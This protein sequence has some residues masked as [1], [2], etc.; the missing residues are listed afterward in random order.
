MAELEL[1]PTSDA[2]I[3]TVTKILEERCDGGRNVF[4]TSVSMCQ[5]TSN[6]DPDQDSGSSSILTSSQ[7]GLDSIESM[8]SA[9][10]VSS[11]A[12]N[13]RDMMRRAAAA[14]SSR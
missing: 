12:M 3:E 7:A 13:L 14:S 11:R 1:D 4:H 6:R 8:A 9:F 10:S 5:P 2:T